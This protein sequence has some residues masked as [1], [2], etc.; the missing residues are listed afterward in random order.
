MFIYKFGTNNFFLQAKVLKRNCG[1]FE[2]FSL[3]KI[4]SPLW[5]HPQKSFLIESAGSRGRFM[6]NLVEIHPVVWLPN[7]GQT[8]KQTDRPLIYID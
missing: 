5:G 6:P 7:P 2:F 1:I 8:D 4:I 3:S